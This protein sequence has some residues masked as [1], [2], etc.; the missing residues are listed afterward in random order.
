M[1][2]TAAMAIATAIYLPF[3]GPGAAAEVLPA[4]VKSKV[5][6]ELVW[7][8]ASGGATTRAR[9]ETVIKDFAAETGITVKGDFNSDMTKFFAA[10]DSGASIPWSF[11]EF[12]TKGDFI[13]AR[14]AGYLQ[15]LDPTIVDFTKIG[16]ASHDEYGVEV[17]RYGIVFTYNTEKFKGDNVPTSIADIYDLKRFPGK[18][19]LFKYPQFGGVLESALLADGVSRDQLYPLNLDKAF[20]KL[21]TIKS[22]ILWWSNGDDAIRL[23]SS[24]ECSMGIAWSGRVYGAVRNDKAPLAIKWDNSLYSQAV[25]AVPVGAPNAEAGQAM[26]AHFIA[27]LE[28]QKALVEQIT[29]TTDVAGLDSSSYGSD[30]APWI[31]AG[32]NAKK[33]IE[34][35]ASYYA[36]HI[37]EVVDRFNRWVALN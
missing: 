6:G 24:G 3:A 15:K 17:L 18:R 14:E 31:V 25:Y 28:G 19:C 35:N 21:D 22:E 2:T 9:E 23:L 20:A 11:V 30:L 13:K 29:Y 10:M 32:D 1:R 8:D 36:Q 16:E 7:H 37:T 34:E 4:E 26:I 33:A 5:S 27:D 12:P